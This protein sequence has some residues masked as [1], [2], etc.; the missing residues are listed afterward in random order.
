MTNMNKGL[1]G[2]G[3]GL[4]VGGIGYGIKSLVDSRRKKD[5]Q[6]DEFAKQHKEIEQFYWDAQGITIKLMKK[7][8]PTEKEMEGIENLAEIITKLV[9]ESDPKELNQGQQEEKMVVNKYVE[10]LKEKFKKAIKQG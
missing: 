8:I 3:I 9:D 7:D 6:R 4:L 5:K 1:L 10:E 2:L